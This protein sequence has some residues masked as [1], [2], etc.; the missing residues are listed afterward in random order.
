M[1][2]VIKVQCSPLEHFFQD[3]CVVFMIG[4]VLVQ[5]TSCI[6]VIEP[7][8]FHVVPGDLYSPGYLRAL[9][10]FLHSHIS[11]VGMVC[12]PSFFW[13]VGTAVFPVTVSLYIEQEVRY[14]E[15]VYVLCQ[16]QV[17]G[18][19]SDITVYCT[20]WCFLDAYFPV[21]QWGPLNLRSPLWEPLF[22]LVA[23]VLKF[24]ILV[25]WQF[26]WMTVCICPPLNVSHGTDLLGACKVFRWHVH[27]CLKG[28]Q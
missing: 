9:P 5:T 6:S 4:K 10:S 25:S 15:L 12:S 7:R 1:P 18:V 3:K 24:A 27:G 14:F 23:Y 8:H 2:A 11:C 28:H 17:C 22:S 16:F 26:N 13:E 20:M 21:T 19:V